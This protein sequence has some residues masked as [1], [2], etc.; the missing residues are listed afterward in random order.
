MRGIFIA[1]RFTNYTEVEFAAVV[2]TNLAGFFHITQRA[3][4]AMERQ[5]RHRADEAGRPAGGEELLRVS[6]AACA[7]WTRIDVQASVETAGCP[8]PAAGW[9][10][11]SLY[12]ASMGTR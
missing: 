6:A 3:I 5:G 1:K 10:W 12:I 4:E 8:L 9:C 7:A 11:S 2:S